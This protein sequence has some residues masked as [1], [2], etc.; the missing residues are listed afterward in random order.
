[1]SQLNPIYV[2]ITYFFKIHFNIIPRFEFYS[3][4]LLKFVEKLCN[5]SLAGRTHVIYTDSWP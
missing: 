3:Y 5:L 2:L 1:M 4:N